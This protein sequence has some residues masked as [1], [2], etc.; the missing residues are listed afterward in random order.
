MT[1][2]RRKSLQ[3]ASRWDSHLYRWADQCTSSSTCRIRCHQ[4]CSGMSQVKVKKKK[5][6]GE[7]KQKNCTIH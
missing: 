1:I 3:Q 6:K 4:Y 7:K 5:F 2:V